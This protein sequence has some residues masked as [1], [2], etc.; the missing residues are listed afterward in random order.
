VASRM[1]QETDACD[2]RPLC[3]RLN[4]TDISYWPDCLAPTVGCGRSHPQPEPCG[5]H[6]RGQ[7][8]QRGSVLV[9]ATGYGHLSRRGCLVAQLAVPTVVP[10]LQPGR[11][12]EG[13]AID[14]TQRVELLNLEV[15]DGFLT[16]FRRRR[17]R[18]LDRQSSAPGGLV[19]GAE[20]V[21]A[22]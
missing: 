18:L 4:Q 5:E 6:Q 19:A 21:A 3:A 14:L 7:S 9:S 11:P 15:I 2:L 16:R 22:A 13:V 17:D 12:I 20:A 10:N 1:S 8:E